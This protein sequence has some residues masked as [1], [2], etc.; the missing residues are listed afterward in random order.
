[1]SLPK[2]FDTVIP[3]IL[4][5]KCNVR[6]LIQISWSPKVL[7]VTRREVLSQRFHNPSIFNDLWHSVRLIIRFTINY[8]FAAILLF[9]VTCPC[10]QRHTNDLK[11]Y[12]RVSDYAD[13]VYCVTAKWQVQGNNCWT[14]WCDWGQFVLHYGYCQ[15]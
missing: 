9:L 14:L 13:I 8:L 15:D 1:M 7:L 3:A 12:C 6:L 2:A 5:Y 10:H 4:L 11:I